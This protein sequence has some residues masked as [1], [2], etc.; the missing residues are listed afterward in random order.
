M[1]LKKIFLY[2][3]IGSVSLSAL[4]GIV[5]ILLGNFGELETKVLLTTLTVTVTSIL[6]LACGA[7][8]ET[9]R[10]RILPFAGIAFAVISAVM[11]MFTIWAWRDQNDIFAKSLMTVTLLAASC[12]HI[13]LL[14][15]AR[16][17]KRFIWARYA[18]HIF[19]WLLTSIL[20]WLIW[21]IVGHVSD[22]VGRVIGVL[23][24]LIGA[25]T[26]ITPIF[27][28]LSRDEGKTEIESIN[29][30]IEQL[31]AQ[32]NE[33]ETRKAELTLSDGE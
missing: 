27:H 10:G 3:L 1:N 16:L 31:K 18:A 20:V 30:E 4:I 17:D 6:G 28:K 2:L 15:L 8:L 14:S 23:S 12:S 33:L 25:L 26:V 13:S 5:V 11:W 32:L 19:V 29:A 9:G 21:T 22:P 24:I 7:Y